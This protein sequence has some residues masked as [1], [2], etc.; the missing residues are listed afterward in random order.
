M[1]ITGGTKYPAA[2]F[3]RYVDVLNIFII[4]IYIMVVIIIRKAECFGEDKIFSPRR[5]STFVYSACSLITI[6]D[7]GLSYATPYNGTIK[8]SQKYRSHLKILRARR[9]RGSKFH[10]EDPFTNKRD[11]DAILCGP[12][13]LTPGIFAPLKYN[14]KLRYV[15]TKLH[16]MTF[17]R[18]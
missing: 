5:D 7:N 14:L 13:D 10:S 8:I 15:N 18:T 17:Q 2:H 9:V 16:D 4:K 11:D 12:N 3:L 6:L 1:V